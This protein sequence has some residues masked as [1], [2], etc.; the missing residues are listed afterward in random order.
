M[1]VSRMAPGV[2]WSTLHIHVIM[3]L[4]WYGYWLMAPMSAWLSDWDAMGNQGS[5]GIGFSSPAATRF[6][7]S[8]LSSKAL[9]Q[10]AS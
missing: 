9:P 7:Y 8:S 5:F 6:L 2:P 1:I 10:R 4:H 3:I